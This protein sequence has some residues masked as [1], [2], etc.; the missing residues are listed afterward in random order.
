MKEIGDVLGLQQQLLQIRHRRPAY[1]VLGHDCSFISGRW[2][3]RLS[4]GIASGQRVSC[5]VLRCPGVVV[6]EHVAVL[7]RG[8]VLRHG[9]IPAR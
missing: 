3:S 1:L 8:T 4:E 6:V 5:L 7:G 9:T 2:A